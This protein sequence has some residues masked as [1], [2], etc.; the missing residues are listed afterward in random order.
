MVTLDTIEN[1][2]AALVDARKRHLQATMVLE[3][4]RYDLAKRKAQISCDES[5]ITGK[6]AD[7]RAAQLALALAADP[8]ILRLRGEEEVCQREVVLADIDVEAARAR[9]RLTEAWLLCE[10]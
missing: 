9:N 6:N 8:E 4:V 3:V 2:V 7:A 10:E 5:V 1:L